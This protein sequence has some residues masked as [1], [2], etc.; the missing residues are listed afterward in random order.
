VTSSIAA[1]SASVSALAPAAPVDLGPL[2]ERI[3]ALEQ[4]CAA[5]HGLEAAI[6]A[7]L[8]PV[9]VRLAAIEARLAAPP[10]PAPAPVPVPV[11]AP[12]PAAPAPAEPTLDSVRKTEGRNLLSEAAFGEPDDIEIIKGIGPKLTALLHQIGVYYFWQIAV[13]TDDD[14][15]YVDS[16][17]E[18]FQGRI[19]RDEWVPQAI[20]FAKQPGAARPPRA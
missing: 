5:L 14:I 20:E 19:V 2:A 8:A 13:W 6:A 10:A 17:L 15:A 3:A 18:S 16:L 12:V 7:L 1:L 9:E 11:P 4:R